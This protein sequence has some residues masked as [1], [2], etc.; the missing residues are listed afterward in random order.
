MIP[1]PYELHTY[2]GRKICD[3]KELGMGYCG[4]CSLRCHVEQMRDPN[5]WVNP[6]AHKRWAKAAGDMPV[7]ITVATEGGNL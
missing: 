6:H 4:S 2:A 7:L 3:A 5:S 1:T